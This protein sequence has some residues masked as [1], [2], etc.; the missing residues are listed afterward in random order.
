MSILDVEKYN[1]LK[2]NDKSIDEYE[3]ESVDPRIQVKQMRVQPVKSFCFVTCIINCAF[4][5]FFLLQGELERLNKSSCDINKMETELE[6]RCI[7]HCNKRIK[8]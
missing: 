7:N 6:V 4:S 1:A 8:L 5:S 3:S 2:L